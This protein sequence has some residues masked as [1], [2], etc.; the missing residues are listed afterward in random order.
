MPF[1]CNTCGLSFETADEFTKHRLVHQGES[2]KPEKR[3]LICLGC[4]KPIPTDSSKLDYTGDI[5]CPGCK[6]TMKVV[7]RNGEVAFAMSKGGTEQTREELLKQYRMWVLEY[8]KAK[9][10]IDSLL[11]VSANLPEDEEMPTFT[12]TEDLLAKFQ[13][14]EATIA[15]ALRK[16]QEI[17]E[18]LH[19]MQHNQ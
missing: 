5:V 14:A 13:Y 9:D 10:L 12:V 19:R 17:H 3:G 8:V 16:R 6:Q 11:P 18:K 15:T 1:K 4:G 2:E 7:M